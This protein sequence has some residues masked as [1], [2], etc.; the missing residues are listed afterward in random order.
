MWKVVIADDEKLIC[1][2]V[3]TLVD[4]NSL[5]MEIIGKAENGLEALALVEQ[6]HPNI[7]ITDIRMPGCDGLEL[8][9]QARELSPDLE[10]I[11][12]SGYAHFKYAQT[13]IA[14]GVGNY[15]LKPINKDELNETLQK[16]VGKLRNN[17]APVFD[18]EIVHINSQNDLKRLREG[19]IK[20]IFDGHRSLCKEDIIRN[21]HFHIEGGVLQA[22]ILKI[23]FDSRKI[24]DPAFSIIRQK[25]EEIFQSAVAPVCIESML[26]FQGYAGCGILNYMPEE[27]DEARRRLREFLQQ[28]E[29]CK[30][31]FGKVEFS[32]G[33][34]K[35]T[36]NAEELA[37]SVDEARM[38]VEERLIEGCGRMLERIPQ[39]S[40]LQRQ[41]LLDRY[42]KTVE[43]LIEVLDEEE[44]SR[45]SAELRGA[46]MGEPRIRG[47]EILDIILNAGKLFALRAGGEDTAKIQREFEFRCRQCSKAEDVFNEL[48]ELEK[49]LLTELKT[50]REN[51]TTRPI[52]QAKQLIMEN[53]GRN[54]TLDEVCE[55]VGFSA[56]YFS[57]MFKKETGEGFSKYLMRVRID[58]AKE[59]LRETN[60]P[61]AEV[62]EAVGYNDRKHFT[63]TF[64]KMTGVNP[65]EFRR[66]Y[67]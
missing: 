24:G 65:A 29:A 54:I 27:R 20:D 45:G 47:R 53:Y 55:R 34:G 18:E 28:L 42:V 37:Q 50:N 56:A 58:K 12:I 13:A 48:R 57:A 3:E 8:I 63:Q 39:S 62:C 5:D 33:L 1:R 17:R 19:L 25:A 9:R 26:G 30:N 64:H 67:G 4:W 51:E 31:L 11:I 46:V 6:L 66:L 38:V 40:G 61:V 36:E 22:F 52:R 41:A 44:I 60:M 10:I 2:L 15:I 59:L 14:Y 16:I 43:H 7:L 49:T 21:Y 23:D 32:L 35:I